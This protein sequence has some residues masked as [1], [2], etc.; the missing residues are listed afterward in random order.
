MIPEWLSFIDVVFVGV[1]LL[2]AWGGFQRGFA[3]Q[4]AHILT[5]LVLG[6]TLFFVYPAVFD[7][8]HR[9]FC[10]I[11]E[12]YLT[13]MILAGAVALAFILFFVVS[14]LL[15]SLLKTKISDRSDKFYGFLLGFLRGAFIA[16]FTM[17]FLVVLDPDKVSETF[18]AKSYAGRFVCN[19]LAPPL[20]PHLSRESFEEKAQ[21]LRDRLMEQQEAGVLE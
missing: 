12:T 13:W 4:I 18:R 14:K 19:Q 5:F 3:A 8:F 1:G 17:V 11:N 16:L 6:V 20:Q 10:R 2:F 7:Y 21:Q 15:Q 9:V